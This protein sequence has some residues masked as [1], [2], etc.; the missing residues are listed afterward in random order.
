M[1][2]NKGKSWRTELS[3]IR[4]RFGE[5]P[6]FE[7][8]AIEDY[9][10]YNF[11]NQNEIIKNSS[12]EVVSNIKESTQSICGTL[13]NGFNT[14]AEI[15]ALGFLN[16]NESLEDINM[17]LNWGFSQIIE[18]QKISISILKNIA[19]LLKVPDIQKERQYFIEQG[20]KFYKQASQDYSFYNDALLNFKKAE[21]IEP[22][23]YFVLQKIGLIHLFSLDHLDIDNA[24]NYFQKSIRY[25]IGDNSDHL[26][27]LL[28][29]GAENDVENINRIVDVKTVKGYSHS[30][31]AKCYYIK[32]DY[33]NAIKHSSVVTEILTV[34]NEKIYNHVKYLC[35]GNKVKLA[36]D[37]LENLNG[38]LDSFPATSVFMRK[39]LDIISHSEIVTYFKHKSNEKYELLEF[40]YNE[41]I[42]I[43]CNSEILKQNRVFIKNLLKKNTYLDCYYGIQFLNTS[44]VYNYPF[45]FE[46][47]QSELGLPEIKTISKKEYLLTHLKKERFYN[48]SKE[49]IIYL[50]ELNDKLEQSK[51]T[52]QQVEKKELS[53]IVA[54]MCTVQGFLVFFIALFI[55]VGFSD[56]D[57]II[58]DMA[59]FVVLSILAVWLFGLGSYIDQEL[60]IKS[61]KDKICELEFS[62]RGGI[63]KLKERM[64]ANF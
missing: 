35:A 42:G 29:R 40:N 1:F 27:E 44:F 18:H 11:D 33:E 36:L 4:E 19:E 56:Y 32:K 14:I 38:G 15:N 31:L 12:A 62:I 6:G 8:R 41:L 7:L 5:E 45:S 16:I 22:T 52:L 46:F 24:I 61:T 9:I 34:D 39:D 17:T 3:E 13:E 10:Y 64:N 28:Q 47:T 43:D 37:A 59:L 48:N 51:K 54:L 60:K 30:H 63:E 57:V 20:L 53:G 21:Q 26:N 2:S 58:D 25:A 50:L 49:D 23:D 55:W